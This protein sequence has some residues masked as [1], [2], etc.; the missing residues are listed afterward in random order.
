MSELNVLKFPQAIIDALVKA[1]PDTM[2]Q[3]DAKNA[4]SDGFCPSYIPWIEVS[5][6]LDEVFG[7]SWSWEIIS[8]AIEGGQW[9]VHGRLSVPL[10]FT[11]ADKMTQS[12]TVFK[13]GIGTCVIAQG[14]ANIGDD[15][16]TAT[17]EAM[18]RAAVLFRVS[19]QLYEREY[20]KQDVVQ[21]AA[22]AAPVNQNAPALPFQ[23]ESLR[24]LLSKYGNY[25]ENYSCQA[26]SVAK[27]DDL[28]GL[29][30]AQLLS[31]QHPFIVWLNQQY[32][33]IAASAGGAAGGNLK[34][35][36]A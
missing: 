13:D 14:G 21:Q 9:I 23:V 17:A 31:G 16:K 7:M 29:V 33:A 30:V 25:P 27:L 4:K 15:L 19:A 26:L 22:A 6:R 20:A 32:P 8:K 12:I 28:T 5:K 18:K 36:N 1:F 3:K 35:T 34:A 2:I 24:K 11:T 10:F